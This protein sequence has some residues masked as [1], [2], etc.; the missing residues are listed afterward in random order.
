MV[1][2]RLTVKVYP[3]EQLGRPST[4][5]Q[6]G[7]NEGRKSINFLLPVHQPERVML[8]NL[9]HMIREKWMTLQPDAG[10]LE[11]KKLVDDKHPEDTLDA[12]L[13]VA[14]V[15]VDNGKALADG[16]DQRGAVRV[17]QQPGRPERYGSVVQDWGA[18]ASNYARP[19]PPL[20]LDQLRH[21]DRPIH[22]GFRGGPVAGPSHA[23]QVPESDYVPQ[24]SEIGEER[25]SGYDNH[26]H[27]SPILVED[28]QKPRIFASSAGKSLDSRNY[29]CTMPKDLSRSVM[30]TQ[31]EDI[32]YGGTIHD[33][34]KYTNAKD[35]AAMRGIER[36]ELLSASM[37]PPRVSAAPQSSFPSHK[38][39]STSSTHSNLNATTSHKR[40]AEAVD[41]YA[42]PSTSQEKFKTPQ[43]PQS[44][45]RQRKNI[46]RTDEFTIKN[47][48]ETLLVSPGDRANNAIIVDSDVGE[49]KRTNQAQSPRDDNV[50]TE[51]QSG[52]RRGTR[53][54]NI[55]G[56]GRISMA[57]KPAIAPPG[58]AKTSTPGSTGTT[59]APAKKSISVVIADSDIE[60]V[61][62]P[63][64]HTERSSGGQQGDT[65]QPR[66]NVIDGGNNDE[67]DRNA[68]TGA[69]GTNSAKR[70]STQRSNAYQLSH[71]D[72]EDSNP[73][74]SDVSDSDIPDDS[75]ASSSR[76]QK[77]TQIATPQKPTQ[78]PTSSPVERRQTPGSGSA[79]YSQTH[80][81]LGTLELTTDP[82]NIPEKPSHSSPSRPRGA[83]ELELGITSPPPKLSRTPST[84]QPVVAPDARGN[85]RSGVSTTPAFPRP[86]PASQSQTERRGSRLESEKSSTGDPRT[87][88]M[89]ALRS[90]QKSTPR[91]V[92]SRR[93][94]SFVDDPKVDSQPT[95]SSAS[96]VKIGNTMYPPGTT[97]EWVEWQRTD[98]KLQKRIDEARLQGKSQ[99]YCALLEEVKHFTEKLYDANSKKI[100]F[101]ITK[102]ERKLNKAKENLQGHPEEDH[103]AASS[104][105]DGHL[106]NNHRREDESMKRS[107]NHTDVMGTPKGTRKK[108]KHQTGLDGTSEEESQ[109]EKPH[110]KQLS[111]TP[112]PGDSLVS[113][114]LETPSTGNFVVAIS[115][116]PGGMGNGIP[117]KNVEEAKTS[118]VGNG[119]KRKR[120]ESGTVKSPDNTKRVRSDYRPHSVEPEREREPNNMNTNSPGQE[121]SEEPEQRNGKSPARDPMSSS[122]SS[123]SDSDTDSESDSNLTLANANIGN[124]P[125]LPPPG[126]SARR[127]LVTPFRSINK[128]WPNNGAQ[129]LSEEPE[130][131]HTTTTTPKGAATGFGA[132][133]SFSQPAP[134]STGTG[135]AS[136][137]RTSRIPMNGGVRGA[138]RDTLKT[139]LER[140][141]GS[142]DEG[143]AK[144]MSASENGDGAQGEYGGGSNGFRGLNVLLRRAGLR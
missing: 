23:A 98:A 5:N 34:L 127:S 74:Y 68:S 50:T 81:S 57:L 15:F 120:P 33:A 70:G 103:H 22:T 136:S 79:P 2:L 3:R 107:K 116:S 67:G 66:G 18:I 16:L 109:G 102:Y 131:T 25:S 124:R 46:S 133:T 118:K 108:L 144:N 13:T 84:S 19:S 55:R 21:E 35:E 105:G 12:A 104:S 99:G 97:V 41:I 60:I 100:G 76:A 141:K 31:E 91:T 40:E 49:D 88:V 36:Q 1:L 54:S 122:D 106:E 8:G 62:R 64:Q 137:P 126:G 95:P 132:P 24:S 139:L 130:N 56:P 32:G 72:A 111:D 52:I 77:N 134:G 42:I 86:R 51:N 45:K 7:E 47:N 69:N 83:Q 75:G 94:V 119:L 142:E 121:R 27:A 110:A 58:N 59:K 14:D 4:P 125:S 123:S 87:P 63:K 6:A 112:A 129:W 38:L 11:I 53:K 43:K 117:G 65:S 90:V 39:R 37:P 29:E 20:F 26:T 92:S 128:T 140:Q 80:N 138:P 114:S 101:K 61:D 28:S 48:M 78:K 143:S 9:A 44:T 71:V 96:S 85:T 17:I 135:G 10:P 30:T 115:P 113:P 73:I 89:S 82:D 93:S